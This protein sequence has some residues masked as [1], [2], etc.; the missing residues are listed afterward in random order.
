M[1]AVGYAYV[2]FFHVLWGLSFRYTLLLANF[3][4]AALAF[5]FFKVSTHTTVSAAS[6]SLISVCSMA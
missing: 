3:L 5:T 1:L 2:Y 6:Y 4:A